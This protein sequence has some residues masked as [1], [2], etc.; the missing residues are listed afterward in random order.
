MDK[1]RPCVEAL[2]QGLSDSF[3]MY[4]RAHACHWNV[5]GPDFHE[6]HA[7]FSEIAGDIYGSVDY[8]AENIR[9]LGAMAPQSLAEVGMPSRIEDVYL[10]S[11]PM[12]MCVALYEANE[13][14]I[15]SVNAAFVIANEIN[16]QGIANFLAERDNMHKKWRW[17]LNAITG[18]GK[19]SDDMEEIP[20]PDGGNAYRVNDQT[21]GD[22]PEDMI[23]FGDRAEAA[24]AERLER[25]NKKAPAS[26]QASAASVHAVYRRGARSVKSG[27]DRHRAGIS[28]VDAFLR[29]MRSG[30]EVNSAY[31][32]DAD[33]LPEKH[34]LS[35]S[36]SPALVASAELVRNTE[37]TSNK[38]EDLILAAAEISGLGYESEAIFRAAWMRAASD[39]DNPFER[40]MDLAL[41]KYDSKDA[42]LLPTV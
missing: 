24:L 31:A 41:N 40:V 19:S 32:N 4:F 22:Y 5:E 17:Q 20:I 18:M 8:W 34:K 13:V 6:Y 1:Y 9:K 2:K 21:V 16:E 39:V 35:T 37:Q 12:S 3:T 30:R 14:V 26:L 29:L 36:Q 10:G 23:F 7:F 28:R 15:E 11:D 42:D 38:P 33:L 27:S 25:Y